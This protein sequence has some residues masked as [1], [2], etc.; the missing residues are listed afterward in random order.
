MKFVKNIELGDPSSKKQNFTNIDLKLL[1]CRYWLLD[2]WDCHEMVFPF[3]RVYWNKNLG[4]E[5][6]HKEDIISMDPKTIY[7]IAPFTSFSTR[8]NKK[9]VYNSGVH[10]SGK[11]LT[12]II[13]ESDYEDNYLFHFFTHFNLG[14]PFDHVY[15][16]IYQISITDYLEE[17]LNCL[18]DKLKS[19]NEEIDIKFNLKLQSFIKEVISNIGVELWKTINID[20][21]VLNVLRYTEINISSKLSNSDLAKVVN[22]APNSFSRLFKEEMNISLHNFIQKRKIARACSLFEYTDKSIE[23]ISFDLGFSNRYHFS[24]V[25]KTV[26]GISPSLYRSGNYS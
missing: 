13:N 20:D 12:E 9:H 25:F 26:T 6:R 1:C 2:L 22:M 17:R 23:S 18:T 10:V 4:G 21:R 19:G 5:L 7:V 11:D 14:I 15:P 24:R 8:F 3:W 16:G